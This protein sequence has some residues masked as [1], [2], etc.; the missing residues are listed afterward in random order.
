MTSEHRWQRGQKRPHSPDFD[1]GF[2]HRPTHTAFQHAGPGQVTQGVEKY[3]GYNLSQSSMGSH[4]TLATKAPGEFDKDDD[5]IIRTAVASDTPYPLMKA[6]LFPD[7]TDI[8]SKS[9][10]SRAHKINALWG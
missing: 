8:S 2:I 6:F 10:E 9:L 3:R 1:E 4:R 7:R 5:E